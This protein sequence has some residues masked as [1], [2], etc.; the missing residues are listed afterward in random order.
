[1]FIWIGG[2]CEREDDAG[3]S[4]VRY[5]DHREAHVCTKS[6]RMYKSSSD[7]RTC[8][9]TSGPKPLYPAT[10]RL[11]IVHKWEGKDESLELGTLT[12]I[13]G[14]HNLFQQQNSRHWQ[15]HLPGLPTSGS[16]KEQRKI[17]LSLLSIKAVISSEL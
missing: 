4:K 5:E 7:Q 12:E 15:S 1:M 14:A 11:Q 13:S 17:D 3:I 6:R 2:R 16:I 8:T 10:C 9:G